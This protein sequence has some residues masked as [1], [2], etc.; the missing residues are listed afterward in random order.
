[1]NKDF[2]SLIQKKYVWINVE[3]F[4]PYSPTKSVV[5][6]FEPLVDDLHINHTADEVTQHL[7]K[8][9]IVS[10]WQGGDA[11]TFHCRQWC[12]WPHIRKIT[13]P[14]LYQNGYRGI[15]L[16][17]S[18]YWAKMSIQECH[19]PTICFNGGFGSLWGVNTQTN[20]ELNSC[21]NQH[22]YFVFFIHF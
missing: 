4:P 6:T 20:Q 16:F 13:F 17:T 19:Y 10:V 22:L 1:M 2:N 8:N 3:T 12:K 21:F 15:E 11:N 7:S 9:I 5:L 14:L 18:K